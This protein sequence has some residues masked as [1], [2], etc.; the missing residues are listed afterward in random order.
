[1]PRTLADGNSCANSTAQIP[2][3]VPKSRT[4]WGP[5]P[6]GARCDFPCIVSLQR[7]CCKSEREFR[8]WLGI[9]G[10]TY[11]SGPVQ[12]HRSE[13]GNLQVSVLNISRP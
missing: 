4:F 10:S 6:M 3:P 2:V 8:I 5:G 11:L 9:I 12:V 7:L 1:M 13:V